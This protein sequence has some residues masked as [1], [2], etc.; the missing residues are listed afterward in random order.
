MAFHKRKPI[1]VNENQTY[2][3]GE[4]GLPSEVT[5][6]VQ[7]QM[8][9]LRNWYYPAL[10]YYTGPNDSSLNP[11]GLAA[12]GFGRFYIQSC[13]PNDSQPLMM[14]FKPGSHSNLGIPQWEFYPDWSATAFAGNYQDW[15]GTDNTPYVYTNDQ[16][17]NHQKP[18]EAILV[19]P[20]TGDGTIRASCFM[21]GYMSC[22]AMTIA[23]CPHRWLNNDQAK[24]LASQVGKND[25]IR[26]FN[27]SENSNSIGE[28]I[29]WCGDKSQGNDVDTCENATRRSA[30]Y[31]HPYGLWGDYSDYSS[32]TNIWG[33]ATLTLYPRNLYGERRQ[34]AKVG[35]VYKTTG[36]LD[37][38][39]LNETTAESISTTG[40]TTTSGNAV[41]LDLGE[42]S[43]SGDSAN[44]FYVSCKVDSG[45]EFSIH[46]VG[47]FETDD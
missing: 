29:Y 34:K 40:L 1:T 22:S 46:S 8:N 38:T 42:I 39:V 44:R 13:Y 10:A 36:T 16:V 3:I 17:F 21:Y 27:G 15:T 23:K 28:L 26:G 24:V 19:G 9:Y 35:I 30:Q 11:I 4:K 2:F 14:L 41:L 25:F 12:N 43:L 20:S 32:L 18:L 31:L 45:E 33:S 47:I 7:N 5:L 37:I 6:G